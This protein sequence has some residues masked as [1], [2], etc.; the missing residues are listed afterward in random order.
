VLE[1]ARNEIARYGGRAANFCRVVTQRW[2]AL[3]REAR[4][5]RA[6]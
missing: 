5:G 3:V 2:A 4:E 1:R 6:A